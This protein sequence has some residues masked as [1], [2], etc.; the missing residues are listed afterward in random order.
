MKGV[1]LMKKGSTHGPYINVLSQ[2]IQ[3]LRNAHGLSQQKLADQ[4]SLTQGTISHYENAQAIPEL[5][6]VINI[7]KYFGV[8]IDVL[9]ERE[10]TDDNI[11]EFCDYDFIPDKLRKSNSFGFVE[12]KL[13]RFASNEYYCYYCNT[14]KDKIPD[15]NDQEQSV[16]IQEGLLM[17][18]EIFGP[19]H[20][21]VDA[22]FGNHEY[23]GKWICNNFHIYISLENK[24]REEKC[25]IVLPHTYSPKPYIGGMGC[26]LSISTGSQP[27]PCYQHII[28]S[29]TKIENAS[30]LSYGFMDRF[31]LGKRS[32]HCH[33]DSKI[34]MYT[35][36]DIKHLLSVEEEYI[37][38][39]C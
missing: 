6:T 26:I 28:I 12:Q 17:T 25:L 3:Y 8:K 37:R 33:F 5:S 1:G 32:Y 31:K 27:V 21:L 23:S 13:K 9:I 20:L 36:N 18:G 19:K 2:N 14:D 38:I 34:D 10:L 39:K 35:Y 24:H 22:S 7:S 11:S 16:K 15:Q 4:L 29:S 30:L